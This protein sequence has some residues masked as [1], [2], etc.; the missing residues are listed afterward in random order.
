MAELE[1]SLDQTQGEFNIFPASVP[2]AAPASMLE[3]EMLIALRSQRTGES[4]GEIREKITTLGIDFFAPSSRRDAS[5]SVEDE[6]NR[7]VKR[8]IESTSLPSIIEAD[9]ERERGL[10]VAANTEVPEVVATVF[11]SSAFDRKDAIALSRV[12][13]LRKLI[14]EELEKEEVSIGTIAVDANKLAPI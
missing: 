6:F 9:E 14:E 13:G 4:I 12:I 1:F 7:K 5:F 11:A 10:E 3:M 8:G 2:R